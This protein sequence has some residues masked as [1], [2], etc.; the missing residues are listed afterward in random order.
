MPPKAGGGA[1][2]AP[3]TPTAVTQVA[4]ARNVLR[5]GGLPLASQRLKSSRMWGPWER[6]PPRSPPEGNV[7]PR[8]SSRPLRLVP[9]GWRVR[10]PPVPGSSWSQ[11]PGSVSRSFQVGG[12]SL[13][14]TGYPCKLGQHR[15]RRRG[16]PTRGF[17]AVTPGCLGG[18]LS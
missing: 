17:C 1:A 10:T 13:P 5:G 2:G 12:Q 8:A 7:V 15:G 9:A 14:R 18:E 11:P 6:G 4:Q 16:F 3:S